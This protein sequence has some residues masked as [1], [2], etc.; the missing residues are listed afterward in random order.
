L[1]KAEKESR[2]LMESIEHVFEDEQDEELQSSLDRSRR[3]ANERDKE[4]RRKKEAAQKAEDAIVHALSVQ[5]ALSMGNYHL[6][7]RLYVDAPNMSAYVMDHFMD[8]ERVKALMV[9]SRSYQR[10]PLSFLVAE[11]AFEHATQLVEFLTE[12]N[13]ALFANPNAP[14]AEKML[15]CRLCHDPLQQAFE[16]KYRKVV[17]KGRI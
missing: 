16:T 6:L 17:I 9:M 2:K 12:H 13:S 15:E 3:L 1:E 5:R 11:L 14:D 8:R 7:F 4:R 10:L